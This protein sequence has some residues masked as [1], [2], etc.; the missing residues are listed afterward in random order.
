[1]AFADVNGTRLHYQVAGEGA[2]VVFIHGLGLDLRMWDDQFQIFTARYRVIRYD[3]RGFGKSAPQTDE[4]FLHAEDLHALLGFL[5]VPKPNVIGL[6]LGGTIALQY[7]L[8]YPDGLFSLILVDSALDG[9][10][11]SNEW[12]DAYSAIRERAAQAGASA[13][14]QMWLEHDLFGPA[15]EQPD[16]RSRLA[17]M[18]GESSGWTW[19]NKSSAR[20]IRPPSAE[21]LGDIHVPALVIVGE[22]DLPDFQRIADI[23]AAGIPGAHKVVMKGVGHMSNME[24]PGEFNRIVMGFLE[25][26]E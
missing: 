4:R 1:M 6:S 19:T 10:D 3:L 7:A 14:N 21:R 13:A 18:V 11:W 26:G 25:L 2:P 9:F 8:L 17:Q 24:G 20:G 23:L 15:R 5:D 16:C 22:R 12:E